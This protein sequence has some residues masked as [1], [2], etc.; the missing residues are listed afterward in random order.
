[1]YEEGASDY[2][3]KKD[4]HDLPDAVQGVLK[5]AVLPDSENTAPLSACSSV[6]P[7]LTRVWLCPSCLRLRDEKSAIIELR[8]YLAN[9]SKVLVFR[10]RCSDCQ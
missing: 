7:T 8:Q 1:M 3:F 5:P 4:L 10:E 6:A 9:H 2:V